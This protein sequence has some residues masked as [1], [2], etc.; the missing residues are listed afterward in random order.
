MPSQWSLLNVPLALVTG[1]AL[2]S[3]PHLF[4]AQDQ[5]QLVA[6]PPVSE[7]AGGPPLD[8]PQRPA[9]QAKRGAESAEL[10]ALRLAE[11]QLMA[12]MGLDSAGNDAAFFVQDDAQAA[13]DFAFATPD[14]LSGLH[15]PDLPVARHPVV[16]KY[17]DFFT[18]SQK[19]RGIFSTWLKRSGRYRP[20]ISS[21]LREKGLPNDLEALVFVES[22]FWPTAKSSAGA[23]GLWQFMPHTARA[24]GLTVTSTYDERRSVWKSSEAAAQH[25]ADLHDRFN[26][27]DLA[28]AAYNFGYGNVE[29]RFAQHQVDDF[30]DIVEAEGILP[31]ETR[32]YVPKVLA[33]AVVLNNLDHFGFDK[34]EMDEALAAVAF[35]VPPG[36]RLDS[37]A[38]AAGTS[39]ANLRSLNPELLSSIIPDP[40]GPVSIHIPRSSAARARVMLPRLLGG[41]ARELDHGLGDHFDWGK[42]NHADPALSRL[43]GTMLKKARTEEASPP[44]EPGQLPQAKAEPRLSTKKRGLADDE[45]GRKHEVEPAAQLMTHR[46]RPPLMSV[47]E[48]RE[49]AASVKDRQQTADEIAKQKIEYIEYV[50]QRGDTLMEIAERFDVSLLELVVDNRIRNPSVL[51]R[52]QSLKIRDTKATPERAMLAYRVRP[53]DSVSRIAHRLHLEAQRIAR[54]N[55][56]QNPHLIRVGQL[57]VLSAG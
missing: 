30:W 56:L 33:V 11:D 25:L 43:A 17:L 52:G 38:R 2:A 20:I 12:E 47:D 4:P 36:T 1:A 45:P 57:I 26:S 35:E 51:L 48:Q 5:R 46:D 34:V 54:D 7:A 24:Y 3:N 18:E 55:K 19:G 44:A 49:A 13:Q 50:I 6:P 39:V 41:Q 42:D 23:V 22:G 32:R 53:G 27:W 14:F 28:L 16:K 37:L 21:A 10:R 29:E 8:A 15:Q 40:G 9:A 31:T